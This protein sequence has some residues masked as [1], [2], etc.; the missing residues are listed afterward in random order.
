MEK[1]RTVELL[2]LRLQVTLLNA[3]IQPWRLATS[4]TNFA[5][6]DTLGIRCCFLTRMVALDKER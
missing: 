1:D 5:H 2:S 3:I 4:E 6:S